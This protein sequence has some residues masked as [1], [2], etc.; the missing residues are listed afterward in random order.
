MITNPDSD[1][2]RLVQPTG[3]I[4]NT[5]IV[6]YVPT[7]PDAVIPGEQLFSRNGVY[8]L[9]ADQA[10]AIAPADPSRVGRGDSAYTDNVGGFIIEWTDGRLEFVPQWNRDGFAT[11]AMTLEAG[12][13]RRVIYALVPQQA[14]QALQLNQRYA[15]EVSTNALTANLNGDH[16]QNTYTLS[17]GGFQVISATQHPDNFTQETTEVYAVEDTL[18][19]HNAMTSRFNGI[20]GN[21]A[22]VLGGELI[23]TVDHQDPE[24][25]DA[26]V[27][28][29]L[30]TPDEVIPGTPGQPGY[31]ATTLAGG[32]YVRGSLTLGLGNQEDVTTTT[33]STFSTDI[34]TRTEAIA[35]DVF[36]TPLTQVDTIT[37][38]TIEQVTE[39]LEQ[40]AA[41]TFDIDTDGQVSNVDVNLSEPTVVEQRTELVGILTEEMTAIRR[42]DEFLFDSDVTVNQTVTPGE[43]VLLDRQVET[44]TDS[45][46]N[47]SPLIGEIA[48]GGVLNF[49]NTP[50][51]PAA[52]TLSAELFAQGVVIGQ[53][54]SGDVGIRAEV[55]VNPFGEE[56][57]P[58]YTYDAEGN[59]I[60]LYKTEPVLDE[61][62]NPVFEQI[63]QVTGDVIEVAVNQF[64]L[65]ENGD[66]IP[67]T[68]G[69]GRNLGPGIF[70]E[71]EERLT[72]DEGPSVAGGLQFT[73]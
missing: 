65:D 44:D 16:L 73:F 9:P 69:T 25:A 62:G 18:T 15:L 66:R 35:T 63:E 19:S 56:Q 48:L 32:L 29:L 52:N 38:T 42:G 17:D 5:R 46:P 49:G 33:T 6:G 47:F 26:R 8:D 2:P 54:E 14:G 13:A 58:A 50:W 12:Q 7:T 40:V 67:E 68:V 31:Q 41:T 1:G 22:E 36:H 20:R 43:T 11:E 57:Q 64:V 30:S 10:I 28:N 61:A 60:A 72:D 45:Y 37:T 21:Y 70:L 53:G 34:E 71:V 3:L 59:L 24:N 39:A 51:T 27:G 23:S 55:V 4:T